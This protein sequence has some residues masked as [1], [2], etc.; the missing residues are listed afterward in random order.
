[1]L[2]F[3]VCYHFSIDDDICVRLKCFRNVFKQRSGFIL[4]GNNNSVSLK[5]GKCFF[6]VGVIKVKVINEM[7]ICFFFRM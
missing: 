7:W 6:R 5:Q 1:M 2:Y 3:D 4:L